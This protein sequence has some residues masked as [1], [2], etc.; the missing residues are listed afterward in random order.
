MLPAR[1][2]KRTDVVAR[3]QTAPFFFAATVTRCGRPVRSGLGGRL[4]A[5]YI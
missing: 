2:D 5:L 4:K 1:L 3:V